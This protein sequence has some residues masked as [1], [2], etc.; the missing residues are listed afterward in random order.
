MVI[1]I[2]TIL[3]ITINN[4]AKELLLNHQKDQLNLK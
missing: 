2:I 4:L 3:F 1:I